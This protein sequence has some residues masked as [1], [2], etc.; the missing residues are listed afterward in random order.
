MYFCSSLSEKNPD[1]S[2]VHCRGFFCGIKDF[3]AIE[4]FLVL[5]NG[6]S[7]KKQHDPSTGSKNAFV[8][9]PTP[10]G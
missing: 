9:I 1:S 6:V 2:R 5:C 8:R 3:A 4:V 10:S 7:G